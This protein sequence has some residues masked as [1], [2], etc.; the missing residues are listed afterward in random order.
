MKKKYEALIIKF[1]ICPRLIKIPSRI[2]IMVMAV[3]MPQVRMVATRLE[4]PEIRQNREI[5]YTA[6]PMPSKAVPRTLIHPPFRQV[7]VR[8]R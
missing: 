4:A 6:V 5:M 2:V 7:K 1:K 8:T 3:S